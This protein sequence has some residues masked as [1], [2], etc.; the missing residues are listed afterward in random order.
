LAED[1]GH[2]SLAGAQPKTALFHEGTRWGIP[3]GQLPT[4]H[5]VKPPAQADL[6]GFA[7]NEHYCLTLARQLGLE[8]VNSMVR[9]FA[10][11]MAIVVERYDR[12][13]TG[14][15]RVMRRHQEDT[16]QSLGVSPWRKYENEG[17]PGVPDIVALLLRE[18]TDA[19]TDVEAFLDALALNWVIGGTD[20][21]AKNY[22]MLISPG[23]VRL[24]PLYDVVSTLPYPTQMPYKKQK[25]AMRIDREYDLWK[26]RR[27]HWEGLAES[28]SLDP[29]PVL[30]R[31]AELVEAAPSAAHE[32]ANTVRAQGLDHEIVE[33][34]FESIAAQSGHCLAAIDQP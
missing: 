3:T 32:A 22:S 23:I 33:R 11:E 4:T 21:H 7:F 8:A 16:C 29:D 19:A 20:A 17:G 18:S 24:A 30:Q 5:I 13:F 14:A 31:V 9:D 10:G 1:E 25:L 26:I 2:F 15:G 28:C 6:D 27:R 12:A 34:L